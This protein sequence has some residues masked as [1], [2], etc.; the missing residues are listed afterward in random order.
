MKLLQ[1]QG[2]KLF[3]GLLVLA[4]GLFAAHWIVKLM[5]R[6]RKFIRIEPTLRGFLENL[7]RLLLYVTVVLT[8]AG[9]MGIPMTSF[10]TLLASAGVAVSLAMQGALGNFVGGVT[11]L[12]LKPFKAGDYVKIGDTEGTAK[13]VGVFYTELVTPDNR[14]ISLPNSSL[15]ST[16]IVNYTREGTRRL[17]MVFGVSYR[18]DMDEVFSVLMGVVRARGEVLSDP[19]PAVHLTE[20]A[21]SCLKFTVRLWCKTADYWDTYFYVMEEGKR[22]LDRAGIEIPYPQLDVHIRDRA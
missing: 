17:D 20:C 7:A 9:V 11:M 22:A 13:V 19:A 8:A 5:E 18:A 16:A 21:D 2:M 1:E 4:V 6:S 14:H 3:A 10:V 12:L 15:T